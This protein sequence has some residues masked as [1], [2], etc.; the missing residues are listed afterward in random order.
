MRIALMF[1]F[2]CVGAC[3]ARPPADGSQPIVSLA[4]ETYSLAKTAR[5]EVVRDNVAWSKLWSE[6]QDMRRLAPPVDFERQMVLFVA[7]GE[8]RSGGYSIEIAR[9]EVVEGTLVVHVR[10]TGPEPGG[11]RTMALTAPLHAVMVPRNDLPVRWFT[12]P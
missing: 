3:A 12:V 6:V 11:I 4:Q 10:E 5:R 9:A 2:I 8:R 1:A 7:L